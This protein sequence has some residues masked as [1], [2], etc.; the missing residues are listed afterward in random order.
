MS[1]INITNLLVKFAA[2]NKMANNGGVRNFNPQN[3]FIPKNTIPQ[4]PQQ[5]AP[6]V[7]AQQPSI[8]SPSFTPQ[9][10]TPQNIAPQLA[11]NQAYSPSG[12]NLY[13][14]NVDL[15]NSVNNILNRD[16][17]T[18]T[19]SNKGDVAQSHTVGLFN[20]KVPT[21]QD[22]SKRL[23]Q[24]NERNQN[25]NYVKDMMKLPQE[26]K[27]VI[28]LI[29]N[30]NV[31]SKV[32]Q[33]NKGLWL[34]NIDIRT[35]TQLIQNGSKEALN[36]IMAAG[37]VKNLSKSE[38]KQLEEAVKY[39]NAGSS[40][41]SQTQALKN[42][43]LLYL[44]WLPLEEGMDFE[45]K[46]SFSQGS[47]EDDENILNIVIMTKNFGEIH[48]LIILKSLS[49]FEIYVQCCKSFPKNL[50]I[51]L[52]A[53]DEKKY[54]MQT[55]MVFEEQ[56]NFEPKTTSKEAKITLSNVKEISPFLLVIANSLIKY[57]LLLDSQA[58][59]RN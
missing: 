11:V 44:P 13:G 56:E 50:L 39:L 32:Q 4:A 9:S 58:S 33:A 15:N 18:R 7:I 10:V 27:E 55:N 52:I 48:I 8:A 47:E 19:L 34:G 24:L 23:V 38:I 43:M 59:A 25:I 54:T 30:Q 1:P 29:Q 28:N 40:Q 17:V 36:Q 2:Q 51:K 37:V 5:A 20:R 6:Q 21:L 41:E 49:S 22:V 57:T 53:E 46:F 26:M 16:I 3:S 42:F 35:L 31:S 12:S 14:Q 45:L